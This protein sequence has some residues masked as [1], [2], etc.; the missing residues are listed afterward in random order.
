MGQ[1]SFAD[2]DIQIIAIIAGI[3]RLLIRFRIAKSPGWDD[4]FVF[5]AMVS[6]HVNIKPV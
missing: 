5:F 2:C 1:V 4:L 3:A 6:A